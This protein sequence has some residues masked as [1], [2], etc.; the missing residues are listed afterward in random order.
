[1][2]FWLFFQMPIWVLLNFG[3]VH[4]VAPFAAPGRQYLPPQQ[5][6]QQPSSQYGPPQ[7]GSG[8][9]GGN[10]GGFGGNQGGFGGSQPGFGQ[11]PP[12]NQYGAPNQGKFDINNEFMNS[13]WLVLALYHVIFKTIWFY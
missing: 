3:F 13:L 12:S 9:F 7:G 8:G 10:Q 1:M 4:F 2:V 5:Q 11:Q 6:G